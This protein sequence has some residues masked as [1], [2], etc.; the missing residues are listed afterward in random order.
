MPSQ[1]QKFRRRKKRTPARKAVVLIR[2]S[3]TRKDDCKAALCAAEYV[4]LY[5]NRS[6]YLKN[7]VLIL[8]YPGRQLLALNRQA[9]IPRRFSSTET[10]TPTPVET[11]VHRP[12]PEPG[13]RQSS[14][15]LT[16]NPAAKA[17]AQ[18]AEQR[19]LDL[20]H[21]ASTSHSPIPA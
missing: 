19:M 11:I 13:T 12:I 4:P 1:H 18:E 3:T 9:Y 8:N 21:F 6:K 10:E 20:C 5:C 2:S 14:A 16:N 7:A 15:V 17:L